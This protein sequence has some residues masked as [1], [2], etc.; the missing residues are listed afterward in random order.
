LLRRWD[1]FSR[2]R[3]A[4]EVSADQDSRLVRNS[5]LAELV[6]KIEATLEFRESRFA[7]IVEID[8]QF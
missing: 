1:Q 6:S 2:K 4:E 7:N 8:Q 3:N 5:A